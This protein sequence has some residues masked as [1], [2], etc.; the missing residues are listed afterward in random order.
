MGTLAA[1]ESLARRPVSASAD[2]AEETA[3]L[4]AREHVGLRI[5][6]VGLTAFL[7]I[8]WAF[9]DRNVLALVLVRGAQ[10]VGLAGVWGLLHFATTRRQVIAVG[11]LA[12]A[13]LVFGQACAGILADDLTISMLVAMALALSTAALLPWG[14][15]AQLATIVGALVSLLANAAFVS[16]VPRDFGFALVGIVLAS[17]AS[18][19]IAYEVRRT[20]RQRRAAERELEDLRQMERAI[21][22]RT[23]R[24]REQ[25][26]VEARRALEKIADA[27]PHILY[28]FSPRESTVIY[29]NR[30][31][32][33]VL[34]YDVDEIL[35]E[36]LPFLLSAIHPEDLAHTIEA[37]RERLTDV[38][39]DGVVE[40][41]LRAR[42]ANGEWRWIHS[43]NIVYARSETGEPLQILGTAQDVSERKR[44]D[45]RLRAHE[46]ELAHVLRVSSLGEL[47]AGLAH[48][49]NQP[50]ASIVSFARGCARRLRAGRA[51]EDTFLPVMEQIASEALR[52]GAIITRLRSLV[53]KEEPLRE[54][55]D[56]NEMV[57]GVTLLLQP[58]ARRLGGRVEL[59]LASELPVLEVDRT[60]IEQVV[61]NLARNGLEAMADTPPGERVLTIRTERDDA[62]EIR[63][64]VRDRGKGLGDVDPERICE[65]FFTT[66]TTGLGMGLSISRSIA[67]AHGGRLTWRANDDGRG[68]TFALE[69]PL[70]AASGERERLAAELAS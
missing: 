3:F 33:H 21:A 39:P 29:V 25:E 68:A 12:I 67:R 62:G 50:L 63:I 46:A 47:T 45:E 16:E 1:A 14:V 65:P 59:Q 5:L 70:T 38:P 36:G 26:L 10:V 57:R 53:R 41:E 37:A 61:I 44:A 9:R 7:A 19:Y 32:T 35:R 58:D 8:E 42:H 24:E 48:E 56:A 6:I 23:A 11:L 43:R 15:R 4:V 55:V 13:V 49:L 22:E 54:P 69:L 64:V 27:T 52:A 17:I 28:L 66:K 20:E 2:E 30:Q 51:D 18:L 40:A 31:V 60:Q 34:G